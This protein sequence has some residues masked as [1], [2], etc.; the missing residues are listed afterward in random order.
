[1]P[2]V[3]YLRISLIDRCNF[4]CQ[5]C[6]PDEAELAWLQAPERLTDEE[7]LT[8]VREVFLPLGIDCFRLTGGEPLLRPGL[9]HLIRALW[10]ERCGPHHQRLQP[11]PKGPTPL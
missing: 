4:R 10:G 6:M 5:Y 8:L 2:T 1:M 11:Q 3:N 9:E 7:I